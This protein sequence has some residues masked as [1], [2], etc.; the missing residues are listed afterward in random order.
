MNTKR[1]LMHFVQD[2]VCDNYTSLAKRDKAFIID[3]IDNPGWSIKIDLIET[4]YEY[5]KF[6]RLT[7]ERTELDW[8]HCFIEKGKFKGFGGP[9]NLFE[10]LSVFRDWIGD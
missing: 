9:K 2:W 5:K 1:E 7:M 3:N 10:I 6:E 4:K 8:Y